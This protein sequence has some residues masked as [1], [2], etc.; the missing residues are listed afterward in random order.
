MIEHLLQFE[1]L[2]K[3]LIN[4]LLVS[5]PEELFWVMFT[6][7]AMG[8]FEYWREEECKKLLNEWDYVR[9]FV[10]VISVAL[11][12]NILRYS[13]LD[14]GFISFIPLIIMYVT[15]VLTGD[16]LNDAKAVRWMGRAFVFMM[17]GYIIMG[18]SEITYVPFILYGTGKTINEIN[19]N[20]LLNFLLTLPSRAI[21]YTILIYF[22][23]KKRTLLK[24]NVFNHI[25]SSTLL[26]VS[27]T[28]LT[29]FDFFVL[30]FAVK[31]IVYERVLID[32][33]LVSQI[34]STSMIVLF[35]IVNLCGLIWCVY[36]VE[37]R[38]AESKKQA[39]EKLEELR[40]E[41]KAYT[42]NANYDN[43]MWKLN[44]IGAGIE[45]VSA[46][47]YKHKEKVKN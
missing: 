24:G 5:I 15:I 37:N 6:L 23:A 40:E 35:P 8:E 33:P 26:T 4:T 31:I 19:Q 46:N 22:I 39:S 43:I 28:I 36:Y 3:I 42:N 9:V 30:F 18:I 47:L 41:I 11:I 13:G 25:F 16:I 7:V 14:F 32:M 29:V 44:E 10:P 34:I 21:Q 45:E 17:L 1:V 12:S 38:A 2:H 20:L 27:I